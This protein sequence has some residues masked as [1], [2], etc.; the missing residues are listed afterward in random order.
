[1]SAA[2][3]AFDRLIALETKHDRRFARSM[4]L[5][6]TVMSFVLLSGLRIS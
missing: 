5:F 6:V 2:R 1:M 3:S 4:L